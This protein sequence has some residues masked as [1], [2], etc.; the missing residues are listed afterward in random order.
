MLLMQ[1]PKVML[2]D[3]PIA[4]MTQQEIERTAELLLSLQGQQTI[5]VVEHDM[6][7]IRTIADKVTVLHEGAVLTEGTMDEIHKDPRVIQVYLG[8]AC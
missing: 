2:V 7:F 1:E 5:V 8:A 4:G 6:A 3:E